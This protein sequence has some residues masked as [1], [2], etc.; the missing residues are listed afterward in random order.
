MKV[1]CPYCKEKYDVKRSQLEMEATCAMCNHNFILHIDGVEPKRSTPA[2]RKK[3]LLIT[4]IS[5]VV[6]GLA[7][8]GY[9]LYSSGFDFMKFFKKEETQ[10]AAPQEPEKP[11]DPAAIALAKAN[12]SSNN[13]K[14]IGMG[15]MSYANDHQEQLPSSLNELVSTNVLTDFKVYIAPS[16]TKSTIGEGELKPENCSYAYIGRSVKYGTSVPVAFEKPWLLS[17]ESSKINVLFADGH[18]STVTINGVA[19][20]NCRQVVEELTRE[21]PDKTLTEQLLKNADQEDTNR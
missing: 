7:G 4:I 13:L 5:A 15:L 12:A 3:I 18:V 8:G 16:D 14:Q 21:N 19:K 6:L 10:T 11:A 2:D 20:M 17:E 1:E 9:Y